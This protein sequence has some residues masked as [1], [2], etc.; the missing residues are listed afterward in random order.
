ME[1]YIKFQR[2]K[3]EASVGPWTSSLTQ[4]PSLPQ[5]QGASSITWIPHSSLPRGELGHRVLRSLVLF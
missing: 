5:T 2:T 3:N 1:I 4:F